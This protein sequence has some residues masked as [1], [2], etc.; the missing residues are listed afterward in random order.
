[1]SLYK[2]L[3]VNSY[4]K[5][6]II[7]KITNKLDGKFYIGRTTQG[8]KKRWQSHRGAINAAKNIHLKLYRAFAKYG[9][10]N[11]YIEEID[12][13]A[14]FEELKIKEQETIIRTKC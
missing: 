13:A 4:M 5:D 6:Y 2:F 9:I 3:G 10:Q 8:L 1:M 7:Y 11:F 12:G 14:S